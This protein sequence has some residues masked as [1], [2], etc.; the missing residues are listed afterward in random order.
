MR[1]QIFFFYMNFPNDPRLVYYRSPE[2]AR[3]N[4]IFCKSSAKI[5]AKVFSFSLLPCP[6]HAGLRNASPLKTNL[7]K[8][9]F[10]RRGLPS[11]IAFYF[12][13][14]RPTTVEF[15]GK[16]VKIFGKIF[17]LS[18]SFSEHSRSLHCAK[19]SLRPSL[20]NR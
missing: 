11:K 14:G 8:S 15:F 18:F 16:V 20:K 19:P 6:L 10:C 7:K 17:F 9:Q 5:S 13:R 1:F 3:K 4:R 12:C 2:A